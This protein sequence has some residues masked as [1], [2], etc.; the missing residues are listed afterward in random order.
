MDNPTPRALFDAVRRRLRLQRLATAL[1]SAAWAAAALLIVMAL[2]QMFVARFGVTVIVAAAVL[3]WLVA[4]G[5][6][7]SRR[8]TPAECAAWADRHLGGTSAYATRLETAADQL[9]RPASPAVEYLLQWVA[10]ALPRSQAM[11]R[12]LPLQLRLGKPV[13]ALLVSVVLT[14]ILQQLP[15]RNAAA[16]W[17]KPAVTPVSQTDRDALVTTEPGAP[18]AAQ[19]TGQA[20]AAQGSRVQA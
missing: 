5:W 12:A 2:L 16:N 19:A 11:L 8:I 20:A 13:M 14:A 4:A 6:T 15:A 10:T 18:P 1:R 9:P 7:A 17:N 3:P